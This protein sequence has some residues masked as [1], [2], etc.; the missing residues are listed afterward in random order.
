M[1]GGVGGGLKTSSGPP[2]HTILNGMSLRSMDLLSDATVH[3]VG[4]V[5]CMCGIVWMVTENV[6]FKYLQ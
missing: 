4:Q 3:G 5:V 2:P 1:S 6:T